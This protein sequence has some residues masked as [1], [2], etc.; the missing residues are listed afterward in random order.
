MI[1]HRSTRAAGTV[2][3]IAAVLLAG[4]LSS[5]E[6]LFMAPQPDTTPASIFEQVWHFVDTEYSFFELK[7]IDWDATYTAFRPRFQDPMEDEELFDNLADML[8]LL[9]DGHVNLRSPFDFSRNWQWF[10]GD[11]QNYDQTLL[12]RN[13]YNGDERY[14]G[15]FVVVDF[16]DVLYVR[17]ASFASAVT[18]DNLDYLQ[19]AYPDATGIILDLRDNGGGSTGNAYRIA[20]RFVD[21]ETLVAY[22]QYKNGP[23]HDAFTE[24]EP[25][26]LSPSPSIW[27]WDR[28][29]VILT[30]RSSYSATNLF[31]ALVAGLPRSRLWGTPPVAAAAYPHSPSSQ[32]AGCC[33][34]PPTGSSCSTAR[35]S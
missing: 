12:E 9:E 17:Y 7:G 22:Q 11:P 26:Y 1:A 3:V 28:P 29:T 23:A 5:C 15:P 6:L 33:G 20:N 32:T 13:Y 8:F 25:V 19:S 21:E 16:G 10:L 18:E 14:V 35:I 2:T 24:L 27:R 31:V 4:L 30:N 34:S